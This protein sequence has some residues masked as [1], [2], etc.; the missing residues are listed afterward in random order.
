MLMY[1]YHNTSVTITVNLELSLSLYLSVCF[2]CLLCFTF[3]VVAKQSLPWLPLVLLHPNPNPTFSSLRI[4]MKAIFALAMLMAKSMAAVT[5]NATQLELMG[6][7]CISMAGYPVT[8]VSLV[9]PC[10]Q[11]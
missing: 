10:G 2:V 7:E 11:P 6:D 5:E 4:A 8:V 9:F 1:Y 3:V